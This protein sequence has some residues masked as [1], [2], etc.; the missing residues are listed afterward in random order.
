MVPASERS[1]NKYQVVLDARN[2]AKYTLRVLSNKNKFPPD[3]A[4]MLLH[5]I[6]RTA[7]DLFS[8]AKIAN[9]LDLY[10]YKPNREAYQRKAYENCVR[11]LVLIELAKPIYEIEAKRMRYW[12]RLL[13]KTRDGLL[14]WEAKDDEAFAAASKND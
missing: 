13:V 11:L 12:T 10:K 7:I 8:N 4:P 6:N 9:D 5:D 3:L 14:E 1:E 2:V